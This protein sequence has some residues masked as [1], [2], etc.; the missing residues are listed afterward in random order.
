MFF[1]VVVFDTLW[2]ATGRFTKFSVMSFF[3]F[4]FF[5]FLPYLLSIIIVLIGT[6]CLSYTSKNRNDVI[7]G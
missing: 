3:Y 7:K 1:A 5:S 6:Q 4:I 2:Q